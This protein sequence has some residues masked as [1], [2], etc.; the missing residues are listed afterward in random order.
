M[1]LGLRPV[2]IVALSL[3]FIVS[4]ALLGFVANRFLEQARD[5]ARL[6]TADAVAEALVAAL[7]A[8]RDFSAVDSLLDG[9]IG[10]GPVQGVSIEWNG[11]IHA[12]RGDT[13][14]GYSVRAALAAGGEV[15]V[16]LRPA[17]HVPG[18]HS[19]L[20]ALYFSVTG[21]GILLLTFFVLTH[22][23]VRPLDRLRH[24]ADQ[25]ARGD[26]AV[27]VSERGAREISRL[28]HAFN[29]MSRHIASDREQLQR[30]LEELEATTRELESAQDQVM[31][32]ERLASVGRLAAGIAH[33]IGNPLAAILGLVEIARDPD[34]DDATRSDLLA[35]VERE[36]ERI[37]G[38][39]RELLDFAR[40]DQRESDV[41]ASA[42]VT[43]VAN[44]AAALATHQKNGKNIR[45][46]I[47]VAPAADAVRC[48]PDRLLQVVLNLLINAADALA[49]SPDPTV[50][51]RAERDDA[52]IRIFVEDNGPGIPEAVL[53]TLFE[54]FVTTKAPGSG[55]GLGLAVTHTIVER[56]GGR[57]HAEAP[58]KG[59]ARFVIELPAS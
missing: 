42:S 40:Q 36:T 12:T 25:V 52:T 28:A 17:R 31:R 44:D 43:E 4:F 46:D 8:R 58:S 1:R 24:A 11:E 2:L 57:I 21:G 30:R 9:P 49:E 27:Q 35:R 59:G 55:T 26:F 13:Q 7:D 29:L 34:T 56:A 33:E 19:Q 41:G 5:R 51:I 20:L 47:E 14:T 10:V 3:A 22:W 23:M 18:P 50:S 38:I 6:E 54:P 16:W 37:S 39:I 15:V 45:V 53:S 48:R 32:S